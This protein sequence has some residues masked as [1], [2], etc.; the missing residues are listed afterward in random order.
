MENLL[1]RN[2]ELW[3]EIAERN[4]QIEHW[5]LDC[6]YTSQ[7]S[8]SRK[9]VEEL[10]TLYRSRTRVAP[11]TG[12]IDPNNPDRVVIFDGNTRTMAMT[13]LITQEGYIA[14][15]WGLLPGE[16]AYEHDGEIYLPYS[17]SYDHSHQYAGLPATAF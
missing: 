16:Q 6:V 1:R 14:T 3:Q 2:T 9:K 12:F 10:K 5:L 4:L 13:E 11:P 15:D 7:P 8:V 17:Y